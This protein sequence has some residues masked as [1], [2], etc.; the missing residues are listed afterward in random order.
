MTETVKGLE[1]THRHKKRG[2]EYM[3]LGTGRMQSED[4]WQMRS[5]SYSEPVGT[6]VDMREVAIYQCIETGQYWVRPR[7]EFEDGRFETILSALQPAAEREREGVEGEVMRF[8]K[9]VLHGDD[10]HRAWLMAAAVAFVAGEDPPP[11]TGKGKSEASLEAALSTALAAREKAEAERDA[12]REVVETEKAHWLKEAVRH[13]RPGRRSDHENRDLDRANV[14]QRILD[15]LTMLAPSSYNTAL[16]ALQQRVRD[17]LGP[18]AKVADEYAPAEPDVF[19]VIMDKDV[20][21][22]RLLLGKFRA[23]RALYDELGGSHD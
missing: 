20:L 7:E 2:S 10:E 21:G 13:H 9:A 1:P 15:K 17:V 19:D 14:A 12:V 8:A 3:L 18:F 23:A 4:W 5:N 6:K 16:A 22:E 11:P